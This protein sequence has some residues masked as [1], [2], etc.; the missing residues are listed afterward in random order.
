MKLMLAE[1]QRCSV[2]LEGSEQA[3][4]EKRGSARRAKTDFHFV[5]LRLR[6]GFGVKLVGVSESWMERLMGQISRR[7]SEV[8]KPADVRVVVATR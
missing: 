1:I 6:F 2:A 4:R 5:K 7:R 3:L 8:L